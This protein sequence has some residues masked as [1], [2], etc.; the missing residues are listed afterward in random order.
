MYLAL[1]DGLEGEVSANGLLDMPAL[2]KA[3]LDLQHINSGYE[4]NAGVFS[5][6]TSLS[7]GILPRSTTA[8]L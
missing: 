2:S 1:A 4:Q 3:G 5:R 8:T 6:L 7:G